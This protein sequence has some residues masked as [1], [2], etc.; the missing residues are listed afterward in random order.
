[1]PAR[2]S[3]FGRVFTPSWP[4][5]LAALVLLGIFVSLGRWQWSRGEAKQVLWDQFND[6]PTAAFDPSKDI[7][8]L[9]RFGR[10]SFPAHFDSEHQ[11]LLENRS[12][13]GK[14]GYEVLTPAVLPGGHRVLVNRGWIPFS[15]YREQL[16]D[17]SIERHPPMILSGRLDE[18]PAAGLDSGRAAPEAGSSWPKLTSFPTHEELQTALGQPLP[19]KILL[20]DAN[21][22]YGF[23]RDWK[24]PGMDPSRHFSYAI[25]WWGFATV[26]LVLY[27][28]LNFRKVS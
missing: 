22:P 26:L 10:F 2:I 15:G 20:L 4:M 16:P 3:A 1:M 8:V 12:Y 5:T 13:Q 19:R 25:Q 7:D 6:A 14:P 9:P 28:G 23:V 27:F 11:F 24:P 18:L 21:A 17:V